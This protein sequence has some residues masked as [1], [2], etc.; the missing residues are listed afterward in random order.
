M[1]EVLLAS[2]VLALPLLFVFP[3]RYRRTDLDITI[4]I[5]SKVGDLQA[6]VKTI[7]NEIDGV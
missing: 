3:E 2:A 6:S 4:D 1:N 5:D 7:E